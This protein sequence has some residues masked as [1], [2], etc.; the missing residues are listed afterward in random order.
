M[1][2]HSV[3]SCSYCSSIDVYILYTCLVFVAIYIAGYKCCKSI[4]QTLCAMDRPA[5]LQKLDHTRRKLPFVS[6]SACSAWIQA[7]K[8][9]PSLL[10][11]PSQR[12]DFQ[13]ARDDLVGHQTAYGPMLQRISLTKTDDSTMDLFVAHP[14]AVLETAVSKSQQ[15][16]SFITKQLRK[17]PC[18][19]DNPWHIVLYSDEVTPGNTHA[20]QNNRKFQAVYWSFLEFGPAAL[21]HEEYW[22]PL[23]TEY[24]SVVKECSAGMSQVFSKLIKLFFDP[25]G[26]NAHPSSGGFLLHALGIR[27]FAVLETVLQD[28]GAHKM[29]WHSRDGSKVC[30][31]CKNLFSVSSEI[32]DTNGTGLLTSG[33]TKLTDLVPET[34][35]SLRDKARHLEFHRNLMNGEQFDEL[36]QGLGLTYHKHMLLI[37]REVDHVD[38]VEV[39][40]HDYMHA[41]W[42]DGVFNLLVFLLFEAFFD[43]ADLYIKCSATTWSTGAGLARTKLK[44]MSWLQSSAGNAWRAAEKLNTSSALPVSAGA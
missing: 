30:L 18:T 7:I 14:W 2:A 35:E 33:A 19:A 36:Q 22:F 26:W 28:G 43:S 9:D 10:E 42:V 12:K 23:M 5:K 21:S 37:D 34:S 4:T 27:L 15:L 16:K 17:N 3:H 32:Q 39:F 6:A 11:T 24:S 13:Q 40:M 31:L 25:Q 38:I 44:P 8:N 1:R 20:P 29:V 41:F